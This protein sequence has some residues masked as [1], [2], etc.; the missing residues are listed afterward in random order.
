MVV[1]ELF[2]SSEKNFLKILLDLLNQGIKQHSVF[3]LMLIGDMVKHS[4]LKN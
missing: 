4:L 2:E 3:L 1:D